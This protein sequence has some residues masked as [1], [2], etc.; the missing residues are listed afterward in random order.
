MGSPTKTTWK[1]RN[2][3]DAKALKARHKKVKK[4]LIKKKQ[5]AGK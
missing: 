5:A 4:K 2:H 3:R 1:K